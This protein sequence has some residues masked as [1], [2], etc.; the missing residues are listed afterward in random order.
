MT[1]N[2]GCRRTVTLENVLDIDEKHLSSKDDGPEMLSFPA[3]DNGEFWLFSTSEAL[4][5]FN[6]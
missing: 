2:E 3:R 4:E 6:A 1:C 5:H